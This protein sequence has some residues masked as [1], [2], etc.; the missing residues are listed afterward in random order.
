MHPGL[1]NVTPLGDTRPVA[2]SEDRNGLRAPKLLRPRHHASSVVADHAR[3]PRRLYHARRG[4][5]A[6]AYEP[7]LLA[8]SDRNRFSFGGI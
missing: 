1:A 6:P 8:A 7:H 4:L 3:L 5:K 2:I